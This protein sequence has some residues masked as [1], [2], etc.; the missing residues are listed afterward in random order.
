[1]VTASVLPFRRR[2]SML[3]LEFDGAWLRVA[4][5]AGTG[6]SARVLRLASVKLALEKR[7]DPVSLGAE[8]KRHLESSGLKTRELAIA[9]GR[10]QVVL[11]AL[12]VPMVSDRRELAAIVNFQ[13]AKDLP[14]RVEDAVVDF[15]VLRELRIP[16]GAE[17]VAPGEPAGESRLELLAGA[18][19]TDV[20]QFYRE[21]A[22]AAGCRL[23]A[24]ALGSAAAARGVLHCRPDLASAT[25][26]M[27]ALKSEEVTLDI[28]SG[29]KLIF[30]RSVT[31]ERG[32]LAESIE[33]EVV[34]SLHAFEGTAG[35]RTLEK[36]VVCG[37]T[38][39]EAA[40]AAALGQRLRIGAEVLD[41]GANLALPDSKSGERAEASDAL[42]PI[43]L[44]LSMLEPPGVPIDFAHPKKPAVRR[45][46][47][48]LRL[49][50]AMAACGSILIGLLAVRGSMI[51]KQSRIKAEVQ[52]QVTEAEK[53]LP[54]YRRV[55]AQTK[56]V[57]AWLAEEKS[58]LDHLAHITALLPGAEHVYVSA[59]STTPQH[60][61]RFAVQ[62]QS[63]D[64][65]AEL[66]KK[67]RAA[68]YEVKPL[69]ITPAND[70]FG[71]HFRTT[72][73]LSIPRKMKLDL[74]GA[75]P[76]ARPADDVSLAGSLRKP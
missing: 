71:Y 29:E 65:L 58:W 37:S 59:F 47:K 18:V 50:L 44:A 22:R 48:R 34:R 46:A 24:L 15:K 3:A 11:R 35:H 57:Q 42:A 31:P 1:M 45:D 66:D 67:L 52:A 6:S 30:S 8:V 54:I 68:G 14:F 39:E 32:T 26:L 13:I 20:V 2:R 75:K 56:T 23:G 36:I 7:D 4:Q 70:R 28:V 27:I 43:G 10:G 76:P 41:P 69:S 72:V 38:G 53:K 62:A 61:I 33:I 25:F 74:S 19:K 9:I 16:A 63:G 17:A 60:V 64:I 51:R 73:E 40:V 55:K 5:A 21:V 49:L 12:Q